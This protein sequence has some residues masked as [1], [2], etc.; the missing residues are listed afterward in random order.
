MTVWE[1]RKASGGWTTASDDAAG[2]RLF[3]AVH[4][5]TNQLAC[6]ALHLDASVEPVN[7]ASDLCPECFA[8][9]FGALV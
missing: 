4:L 1:W 7:E 6:N 5:G 8:V 2:V 3:H 9:V